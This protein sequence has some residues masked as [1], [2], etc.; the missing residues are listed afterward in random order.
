MPPSLVVP[1]PSGTTLSVKTEPVPNAATTAPQDQ[2]AWTADEITKFKNGIKR[3]VGI[4]RYLIN[5]L[6]HSKLSYNK[7]LT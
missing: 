7:Q 4:F 5:Q 1:H 3:Y 6:G 2:S